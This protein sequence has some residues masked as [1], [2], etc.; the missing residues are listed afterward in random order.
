MKNKLILFEIFDMR[1]K[2]QIYSYFQ[3]TRVRKPKKLTPHEDQ[4]RNQSNTETRQT[5]SQN[6]IQFLC[7]SYAVTIEGWSQKI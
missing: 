3:I 7:H 1:E 4:D 2:D 6:W 5:K